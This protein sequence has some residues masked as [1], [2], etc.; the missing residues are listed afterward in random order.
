MN[1]FGQWVK[2]RRRSMGI[3]RCRCAGYA[4]IDGE[5]LRLIEAGRTNPAD[6]KASTLYSLAHALGLEPA[7]FIER[8]VRD[9]GEFVRRFE[10]CRKWQRKECGEDGKP[11]GQ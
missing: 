10:F 5:T 9:D 11:A 2:K 3:G 4:G 1:G 8:A 6:C 7:A